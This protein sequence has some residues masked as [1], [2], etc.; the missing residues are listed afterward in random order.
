MKILTWQEKAL[1]VFYAMP[2][3]FLW[4]PVDWYLDNRGLWF[5]IL[6]HIIPVALAYFCGKNGTI[7]VFF[8]GNGLLLFTSLICVYIAEWLSIPGYIHWSIVTFQFMLNI[9]MQLIWF[10]GMYM[11]RDA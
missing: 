2:Y 9:L 3:Y 1:L 4:M 11:S 10:F 8:A 7:R 6:C 5:G